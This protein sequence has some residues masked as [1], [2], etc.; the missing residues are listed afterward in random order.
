MWRFL[1]MNGR[2]LSILDNNAD[3]S[4]I[5]KS[6]LVISKKYSAEPFYEQIK[7]DLRRTSKTY[8]KSTIIT[9]EFFIETEDYL[10][11]PRNYPL[12]R[13][14]HE[15]FEIID[16]RHEGFPINIEHRI[17]PRSEAQE[18][19]IEILLS[20]DSAILQLAPGVGKTVISIYA[21]AERK[22]KTFILVHRDS[23][24]DQWKE[25]IL[26][27]TNLTSDDV[28]RVTSQTFSE[29][30]KKSISICTTQTFLS[31]LKRNPID[32]L[33][34]LDKA[35]IGAFFGDEV[36]TT[37]GAP[38]FSECSIR[39]PSKYTYGLSA[40]PYRYDGNGDI[41][42]YH[43][44]KIFS[45]D[46]IFGTMPVTVT[47]ILADFEIDTAKRYMYVRW[48]GEFQRA[49]YLNLMKKS[50]TFMRLARGLIDKLQNERNIL[51]VAERI[52]LID[53]LYAST[54]TVNKSK[55][56][57]SAK[58]EELN[59]QVTFATPGKCRDGI[60]APW[61]DCVVMTSPIGN[62]EQISGRVQRFKEDK[63]KPIM[64]DIV[65][66]GC[67]DIARTLFNRLKF[68]DSKKWQ[69][70]FVLISNGETK[71]I[72]YDIAIKLISG[73]SL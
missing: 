25:R 67:R 16:K 55:F 4:F 34:E 71:P 12:K 62:I 61:K 59:S 35:N 5:L 18:K 50:E 40:T 13:Y 60:D 20:N 49:R 52:K 45:D 36:H 21:I 54:K 73:G 64:I 46:D 56:Y 51:F 41:I 27:F 32:F 69:V 6:A 23:L 53:E 47:V 68:Y 11:I 17:K 63:K 48:G 44:G 2:Q 24:A 31:L 1:K 58:L 7:T 33:Q 38:T 28:S 57:Q 72:P 9:N 8:N 26:T 30:L 66:Y 65:D 19:A 14:V 70:N 42:E 29:D 10:I 3:K 39:I 37:V 22:V 15:K 43:L